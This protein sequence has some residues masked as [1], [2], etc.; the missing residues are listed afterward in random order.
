MSGGE[1]E[2]QRLTPRH[3]WPKQMG[4]FRAILYKEQIKADV[5]WQKRTRWQGSVGLCCGDLQRST[6]RR[7]PGAQEWGPGQKSGCGVTDSKTEAVGTGRTHEVTRGLS[8]GREGT[9]RPLSPVA[10]EE[11]PKRRRRQKGAGRA[12]GHAVRVPRADGNQSRCHWEWALDEKATK[13]PPG[14]SELT[15]V[16]RQDRCSC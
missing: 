13:S 11:N 15:L 12:K 7:W 1:R 14:C 9:E 5:P 4:K 3:V 16:P 2:T 8:G 10:A 6:D